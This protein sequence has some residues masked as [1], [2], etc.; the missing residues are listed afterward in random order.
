MAAPAP[1]RRPAAHEGSAK[2]L[3]VMAALKANPAALTQ[4]DPGDRALL[5]AAAE[6]EGRKVESLFFTTFP[7]TG[8][9]RRDLYPEHMELLAAGRWAGVRCM[10]AANRS[11]KTFA[12]AFEGACHL[13]GRYPRWWRGRRFDE[14]VRMWACGKLNTTV[15]EILQPYL[16]GDYKTA[17][18]Y[19]SHVTGTGMIP[20][21]DIVQESLV[22]R[23]GVSGMIESIKIRWRGRGGRTGLSTLGVKSYQQGRAAF[24]G[25][26]QHMVWFDE[27]PSDPALFNEAWTR[28]TIV[29]GIIL[30]TFTPLDGISDVVKMFMPEVVDADL[31][32]APPY[33]P[34][35]VAEGEMA[36]AERAREEALVR[37]LT[38][39]GERG[40]DPMAGVP[41]LRYGIAINPTRYTLR[42][43]WDNA[44]LP[45]IPPGQREAIKAQWPRHEWPARTKGIPVLSQG[46][47][48]PYDSEAFVVPPAPVAPWMRRVICL[49]PGWNFTGVAFLAHDT[50]RDL[51]WLYDE[52]L[53]RQAPVPVHARAIRTRCPWA[54]VVSDPAARSRSIEDGRRLI[55]L[56][57]QEGL[58]VVEADQQVVEA[59]IEAM[60][61]RITSG[62]LVVS[63]HC[64]HFL[65]EY[66]WYRRD[67]WGRPV[68]GDDHLLDA[69]RYGVMS[70]L[71]VARS[72]LD[73]QRLGRGGGGEVFA[74]HFARPLDPVAGY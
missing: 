40:A 23:Q 16:L 18:G 67:S 59:G 32:D 14:P 64:I 5:L 30:F 7:D 37:A 25:T 43:G 74:D 42:V 62:R 36:G 41:E 31:V 71:R 39:L 29:S 4:I 8:A 35:G 61:A 54:P 17:R 50:M 55:D 69:T 60:T 47:I 21:E 52:Y 53:G 68:K 3:R 49:D 22:P 58:E 70:G 46:R 26:N 51:V 57:R 66:G 9:L 45:H 6:A 1:S 63:A 11:G 33:D 19:G 73:A 65:R 38:Q 24:E 56:Y 20:A 10:M 12:A 28:T 27:E 48:Y 15:R 2:L 72:E 13:T 34:V 44:V